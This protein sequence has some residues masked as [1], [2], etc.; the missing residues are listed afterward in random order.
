MIW[1]LLFSFVFASDDVH[2]RLQKM[3]EQKLDQLVDV[4]NFEK[5]VKDHPEYFPGLTPKKQST[6]IVKREEWELEGEKYPLSNGYRQFFIAG[7][8]QTLKDLWT[9]PEYFARVYQL[10]KDGKVEGSKNSKTR[11]QSRIYKKV[12]IVDDQD[13]T[14]DYEVTD[15]KDYYFVRARLVKDNG[16]FALRDNF[17]VLKVVPGGMEVTVVDYIYPLSSIVRALGPA[18]RGTLRD[19]LQ[20]LNVLEKC[21]VEEGKT[22]PPPDVI[23]DLCHSRIKPQ[24]T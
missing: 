10:D 18:V 20:K 13:Y 9:S 19:E 1:L 16:G 7:N 5:F 11:F 6:L 21:F 14:L 12:P 2:V 22:F 23:F 17:K 24:K 8:P 15:K 3:M 4:Q